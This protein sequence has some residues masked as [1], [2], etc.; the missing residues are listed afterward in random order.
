MPT[1]RITVMPLSLSLSDR[2]RR[3][4]AAREQKPPVT[5][6]ALADEFGV[7]RER[8]RQIEARAIEK[9]MRSNEYQIKLTTDEQR[10]INTGAQT[11]KLLQGTDAASWNLWAAVGEAFVLLRS[12]VIEAT[13]PRSYKHLFGAALDQFGLRTSKA[14]R[15]RLLD[16]MRHKPEVETWLSQLAPE[17][18]RRLKHPERIWKKWNASKRQ[19]GEKT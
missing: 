11:L 14:I 18:A 7:T 4:L 17:E 9:G 16:L 12:K 13:G 8:V 15:S 3:I 19:Q 10:V 6:Q 2:E 1:W 5:L